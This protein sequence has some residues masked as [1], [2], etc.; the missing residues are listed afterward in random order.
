MVGLMSVVDNK[1]SKITQ[2]KC[3]CVCVCVCVQ[4]IYTLVK[5]WKWLLEVEGKVES[6]PE[7]HTANADKDWRT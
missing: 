6:T 5:D 3:V 1:L 4:S 7:E 2:S